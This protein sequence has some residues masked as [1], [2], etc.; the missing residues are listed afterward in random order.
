MKKPWMARTAAPVALSGVLALA[1]A[2]PTRAAAMMGGDIP[3]LG[4]ASFYTASFAQGG[5]F[6]DPDYRAGQKELDA[7]NF[8]AAARH[9]AKLAGR[10]GEGSDAARYWQAYAQ[11]KA[12]RRAEALELLERLRGEHPQSSWLDDARAL[13]QELRGS[14]GP[15]IDREDDEDDE[16]LNEDDEELKLYALNALMNTDSERAVATLERFLASNH[17]RRLLE[18][19]LFVLSQS[20]A[21]RARQVLAQ[22][23]RGQGQGARP[24]LRRKAI[25]TLGIAGDEQSVR[26]LAEIYADAA[27][28]ETK[29]A[30]LNAFLIAGEEEQ[31]LAAAR[32]ERDA[33]LRGKAIGVL[34][35]MG[36]ERQ[37]REMYQAESAK[38]VKIQILDALFVAG[39]V[40][41]LGKVATTDP[42]PQMRLKA[43]H[44]L[45]VSDARETGALLVTLYRGGDAATKRAVIEALFIQSSA[46]A[47]LEIARTEP[48]RA[49]RR[50]A[51]QRLSLMDE[52]EALEFLL[53]QLED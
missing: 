44:G 22:V 28:T 3:G 31:V 16:E 9:F 24:E 25:E 49:L 42:D 21:P 18:Q 19:A 23:A 35:A 32:N 34:G 41:T 17:S 38:A 48:D 36:A 46:K 20:D 33:T 40:E 10:G 15:E 29:A 52:P 11:S 26:L 30:V 45:G 50:E 13:E 4:V 8:E 5:T 53:K 2:W 14:K 7:G 1:A 6:G 47:L 27:D 43:I 39:D 37:L 51:L 12:G